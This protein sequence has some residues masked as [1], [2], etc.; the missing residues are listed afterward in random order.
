MPGRYRVR[1]PSRSSS[2]HS[3]SSISG[4]MLL[5]GATMPIRSPGLIAGGLI[6]SGIIDDDSSLRQDSPDS[7][8]SDPAGR[9]RDFLL[10]SCTF[11]DVSLVRR[12]R[13]AAQARR[14][15]VSTAPGESPAL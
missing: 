12:L 6:R 14:Y 9:P 8:E 10:P 4:L 2:R 13:Y 7:E 11:S 5:A 15:E 1:K 3:S